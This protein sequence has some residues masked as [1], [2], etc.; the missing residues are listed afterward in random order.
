MQPRSR[1]GVQPSSRSLH[2]RTVLLLPAEASSRP[3]GLNAT[4]RTGPSCPRKERP[5]GR[6]VRESQRRIVPSRPAEA[7]TRPS[8]GRPPDG[9]VA[10]TWRRSGAPAARAHDPQPHGSVVG[11]GGEETPVATERHPP[12][13]LEKTERALQGGA[14]PAAGAYVPQEHQPVEAGG[15]H[16]AS[17]R[18][19]RHAET[20]LVWPRSRA[21]RGRPL[22]ALHSRAVLSAPAETSSRPAGWTSPVWRA[23]TDD[24][25]GPF[26]R[27]RGRLDGQREERKRG[28]DARC[29]SARGH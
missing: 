4:P 1:A 16:G 9:S 18:A 25:S 6:P 23:S 22:R 2:S 7:S 8:D 29:H 24:P 17:V 26:Q 19:E 28:G 12:D 21:P 3:L 20:M 14:A 10:M 5:R 13:R 27:R 11:A 15:G